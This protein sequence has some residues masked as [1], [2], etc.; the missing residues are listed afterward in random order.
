MNLALK[1][2]SDVSVCMYSFKLLLLHASTFAATC[3]NLAQLDVSTVCLS[4]MYTLSQVHVSVV[5]V[6]FFNLPQLCM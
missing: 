4:Y 3:I 1:H 5:A 2:V 6:T